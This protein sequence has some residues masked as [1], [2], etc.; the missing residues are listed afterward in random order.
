MLIGLHTLPL[1]PQGRLALPAGFR[2]SLTGR[3]YL[4]RGFERNL[5]L[6]G[7]QAFARLCDGLKGTSLTDP[8]G[9]QLARLLLGSAVEIE[10]DGN[11]DLRLPENLKSFAGLD[12]QG[13]L[14]GQGEFIE[15][16]APVAWEQQASL[17]EDGQ[18]DTERFSRFQ[19]TLA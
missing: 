14:L 1:D 12:G 13:I 5:M 19:L 16:W 7:E 17:L 2:Q 6:L 18:A 11:G 8:A 15:I 3:A 9:R 10:L 4:T